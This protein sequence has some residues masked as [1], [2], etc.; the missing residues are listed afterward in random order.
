MVQSLNHKV[1]P[2]TLLPSRGGILPQQLSS[3]VASHTKR[4][5]ANLTWNINDRRIARVN[6]TKVKTKGL[7]AYSQ[8][9]KVYTRKL[10][11]I[12]GIIRIQRTTQTRNS[13][14]RFELSGSL[15]FEMPQKR[16]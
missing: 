3:T 9:P 1:N 6:Q 8:N 14:N 13:H 12:W 2:D 11:H 15:Y 16:F 7:D 4:M 10:T 5:A